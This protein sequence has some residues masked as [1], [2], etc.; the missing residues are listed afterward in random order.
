M[1]YYIG[2]DGGGTKTTAA[3]GDENGNVLFKVTGGTVNFYGVGMTKARENF[4]G[5]IDRII[6]KLGAGRF[7]GVFI[8]SSALT[9]EADEKALHD[10]TDGIVEADAIGMNSD[11]FAALCAMK[12]ELPHA[13]VIAGTG[14]IVAGINGKGEYITKGGWGHIFGDEGSAYAIAVGALRM[15]AEFFD[16]GDVIPLTKAAFSYFGA[17]DMK[18]LVDAVY[19]ENMTKEKIAGFAEKVSKLADRSDVNARDVM[20]EESDR[21]FATTMPLLDDMPECRSLALYG[22]VFQNS[23]LYSNYFSKCVHEEYS[24]LDV[25]VLLVPP[26]EGALSEAIKLC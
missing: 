9:G 7:S 6:E 10:F 22:G 3:V 26:E 25:H 24:D 19:A 12:T 20:F 23:E 4:K 2:I 5:I 18:T 13:I 21:L 14:S 11:V 17:S 16:D 15:A 1:K 8:G